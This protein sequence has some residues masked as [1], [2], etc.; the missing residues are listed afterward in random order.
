MEYSTA[1]QTDKVRETHFRKQLQQ[2]PRINKVIFVLF[3]GF[4]F[5]FIQLKL[6]SFLSYEPS[7][8]KKSFKTL[9]KTSSCTYKLPKSPFFT[10]N[11]E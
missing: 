5:L 9:F 6:A 11:F 3:N 10:G 1:G 7:R 8:L 4:L 2:E